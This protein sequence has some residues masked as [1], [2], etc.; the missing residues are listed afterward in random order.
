MQGDSEPGP[1]LWDTAA[2]VGH[3]VSVGSVYAL[4]AEQAA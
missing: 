4:L 3:P 2:L 1:Q